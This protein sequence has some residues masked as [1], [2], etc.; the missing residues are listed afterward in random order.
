MAAEGIVYLVGAGPG[1][2]ELMTTRGLKVLKQ[3]D[4]IV[5]DRLVDKKLLLQ[6]PVQCER[7][8]A[9][10][11]P[12]G[13]RTPQQSINLMLVT[14]ARAGKTVVRLKGGDPFVFGRGGEEMVFCRDAGVRCEVVPGVSSVLGA[15]ASLNVPATHRRI[16]H[17]LAVVSGHS[18]DLDFQTLAR[19]DTLVIL[20]AREGLAGTLQGLAEA[21]KDPQTPA[22]AVQW[23]TTERERS[24]TAD[25]G[26][27]AGQVETEGLG[28]P[29][30]VVVGE[31]VNLGRDVRPDPGPGQLSEAAVRSS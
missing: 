9:G 31:V 8:E 1:D 17:N 26:T 5:Y 22:A 13:P 6:A 11:T 27:L 7:V 15:L 4:V 21:G 14:R 28:A 20:M 30:V 19:M 3:A 24:L 16:S 23:A 18:E 12:G 25:L 29:M 10:K 2:P